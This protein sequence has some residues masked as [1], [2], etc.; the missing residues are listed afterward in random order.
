[1]GDHCKLDTKGIKPMLHVL[2]F[3]CGVKVGNRSRKV[4]DVAS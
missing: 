2:T 3:G 1:M 4:T